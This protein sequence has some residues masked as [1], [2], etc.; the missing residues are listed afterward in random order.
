MGE[1]HTVARQKKQ[2]V[3]VTDGSQTALD[4]SLLAISFSSSNT[5]NQSFAPEH[6]YPEGSVVCIA[7]FGTCHG[8]IYQDLPRVSL[9][10]QDI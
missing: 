3:F 8:Q 10:V 1:L 9:C 5:E 2:W 6:S 4:N 7:V